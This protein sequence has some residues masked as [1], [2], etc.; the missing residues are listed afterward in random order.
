[1]RTLPFRVNLV[2][3]FKAARER[4]PSKRRTRRQG[5]G[6]EDEKINKGERGKLEKEKGECGWSLGRSDISGDRRQD[7]IC[8]LV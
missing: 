2:A 1:M 3:L 8:F 4:R 7:L 5:G 6:K